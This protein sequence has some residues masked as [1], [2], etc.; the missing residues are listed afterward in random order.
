MLRYLRKNKSITVINIGGLAFGVMC[1]ILIILH[2][3]KENSYNSAIPDHDQIF[4]LLQKNPGSPL[5]NTSISYALPPL[6]AGNFS[7][8][9]YYSRTENYSWFQNC[10]VSYQ[11]PGTNKPIRFNEPS[12]YLADQDLFK[13]IQ[14]PFI[15]GLRDG[16]LN[17]PNSIVLTKETAKKYFGDGPALG[18]TLNL[19]N[20]Y[21]FHVTGVVDI[22]DYVTFS[23]AMLAPITTIR[24]ASKLSGWDNNGQPLFKLH[25]NVDYREFNRRIEHFYQTLNLENMRDPDHLSLALLPAVKRRLYYNKNPL[26]LL[27]FIGIVVLIVSILNYVNMSTS[28]VRRRRSEIAL[29]KISGAN[30]K[31]IGL[32]FIKETAIISLLAVLIGAWFAIMGIPFFR[33]LTG[34]DI[35]PFF[36]N[37]ILLFVAG[38]AVI[39]AIVTLLSGFY[40]AIILSGVKPLTLFGKGRKT[41]GTIY[42]KN[43]LITIQ[44]IISTLLIILT[45]MVNRQYHFMANMPLGFDSEL[46]MQ[47]PLTNELK[48]KFDQVK[49]ELKKISQVKDVC[50]ASSMP[51][52]IP[53]HSGVSWN[54]DEGKKHEDSFGFAIVSAGYTQTFDMHLVLGNEFVQNKP[55]EL[56]GIIINEKAARQLGYENPVGRIMDFWGRPNKIVGV[57]KDF[58]NNYLFDNIKPMVI[59]AH[60][61][62]QHFTKYLF[63]SLFPGEIERTIKDIER[64]LTQVSPDFPFEYSFT[65]SE[66]LS[67][68]AEIKEINKTFRFA[69]VVSIFLAVVGL[70]ALTYQATQSRIKEIGIR[71]VNGARSIEILKLLNRAFL[72]NIFI[73]FI[74]A[75]PI[76]WVIL[77]NLSKGIA[78]KAEL[79]WWIFALGGTIL[80]IVAFIT[81]NI[82]SWWAA[83]RNPVEALRY[84]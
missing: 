74:I 43:I 68:I 58:Q 57:V 28:S 16:A 62:N 17:D 20:E 66:V 23:F 21:M 29:K 69:S 47:L 50:A 14:Y 56:R 37:H 24:P 78:N 77:V 31:I 38:C 33:N 82:Q 79:S 55:E 49:D 46:V 32:D 13:I 11:P 65:S 64:A 53:N 71:K 10:V 7:E 41:S 19:N 9:E 36:R 80:W 22:P 44:F 76:A 54:D 40:P 2:V 34:S 6:L 51:V 72:M 75:C 61:D 8:I 60:P 35:Y 81:M 27:I 63:V 83:R 45:L 39:W 70:I 1:A 26:F 59:S 30:Y 84:E 52:G 15:E 25:K 48:T 4:Y 67:Y 12:F 3:Y 73:A 42:G 18:K 5:G